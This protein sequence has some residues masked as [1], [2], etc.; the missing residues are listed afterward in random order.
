MSGDDKKKNEKASKIVDKK[1][2]A[3][4]LMKKGK[5][6]ANLVMNDEA[7]QN[8]LKQMIH[9]NDVEFPAEGEKYRLTPKGIL[10]KT[11][12]EA[13]KIGFDI[14]KFEEFNSTLMN[15]LARL[16]IPDVTHNILG[17]DFNE[18][19]QAFVDTM[20]LL[21]KAY[22]IIQK[23]GID[24][25]PEEYLKKLKSGIDPDEDDDEDEDND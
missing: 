23:N 6:A 18:F 24:F 7:G 13:Y 16:C 11:L 2:F 15:R 14:D 12:D 25:D 1:K 10:W 5:G 21:G 4:S 3:E 20:N 17:N 19:F 22:Q 8:R 9:D